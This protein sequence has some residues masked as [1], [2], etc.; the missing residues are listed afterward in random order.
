MLF[1]S[2]ETEENHFWRLLRITYI[3]NP[4][5]SSGEDNL[6]ANGTTNWT[7]WLVKASVKYIKFYLLMKI[8]AEVNLHVFPLTGKS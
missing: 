6:K 2:K 3:P 8:V 1:V 4:H 7:F 5:N